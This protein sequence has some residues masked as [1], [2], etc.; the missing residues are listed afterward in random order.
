MLSKQ[1]T[2]KQ[3]Q[4][5]VERPVKMYVNETLTSG[6]ECGWFFCEEAAL[7]DVWCG[8]MCLQELLHSHAFHQKQSYGFSS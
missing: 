7:Q 2:A 8:L 6:G 5:E 4:E 1:L 3:E